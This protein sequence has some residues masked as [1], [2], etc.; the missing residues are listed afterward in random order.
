VRDRVCVCVCLCVCGPGSGGERRECCLPCP[1]ER[2]RASTQAHRVGPPGTLGSAGEC[3]W[4]VLLPGVHV[5]A[6]RCHEAGG[7]G[8]KA[9]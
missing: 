6:C 5:R 3:V 1:F 4:C 7:P 8:E 9:G 2:G